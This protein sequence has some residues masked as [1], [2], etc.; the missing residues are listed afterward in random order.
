M[1]NLL[2]SGRA[3]YA[4]GARRIIVSKDGDRWRSA[5]ILR[6]YHDL[7]DAALSIRPDGRMMVMGGVQKQVEG[8]RRT[9]TFVSLKMGSSFRHP[10]L[11]WHRDDG[12]GE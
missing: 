1:E 8:Q 6:R 5:A 4:T 12:Y 2:P 3:G 7:R 10:K 11:C 9:G